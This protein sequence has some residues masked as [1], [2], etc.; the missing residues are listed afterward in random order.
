MVIKHDKQAFTG[1]I[2]IS[3][4]NPKDGGPSN[5]EEDIYDALASQVRS[6]RCG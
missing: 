6:W 2:Y 4:R 1:H 5:S 3:W